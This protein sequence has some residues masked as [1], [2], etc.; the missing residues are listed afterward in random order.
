MQKLLGEMISSAAWRQ[1]EI[2]LARPLIASIGHLVG[3]AWLHWQDEPDRHFALRQ[4][5]LKSRWL[6]L[7]PLWLSLNYVAT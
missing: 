2:E 6:A 5:C 7:R 4:A 1:N 3:R